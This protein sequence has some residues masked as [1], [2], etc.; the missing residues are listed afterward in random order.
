MVRTA[1]NWNNNYYES[2]GNNKNKF[3]KGI[4]GLNKAGN[5]SCSEDKP[6]IISIF[7][8]IDNQDKQF[9]IENTANEEDAYIKYI[10][11]KKKNKN[12]I[13]ETGYLTKL[14]T[15]NIKRGKEDSNNKISSAR[16]NSKEISNSGAEAQSFTMNGINFEVHSK[17][18]GSPTDSFKHFKGQISQE[19]NLM[20]YDFN[21]SAQRVNSE[22]PKPQEF[23]QNKTKSGVESTLRKIYQNKTSDRF[24]KKSRK[25]EGHKD[26]QKASNTKSTHD[27]TVDRP[28]DH[29]TKRIFVPHDDNSFFDIPNEIANQARDQREGKKRTKKPPPLAPITNNGNQI[30]R[31]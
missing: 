3:V 7:P 19:M 18:N 12:R 22:S 23:S 20:F 1:E 5:Q 15:T 27:A 25:E 8:N 24:F 9:T 11:S 14:R 26:N 28:S 29:S 10:K 13:A 4:K 2:P 6:K 17:V 30:S 31:I 16:R 21:G